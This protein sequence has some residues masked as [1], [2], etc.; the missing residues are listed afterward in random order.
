MDV[1]S[2]LLR[3]K[4]RTVPSSITCTCARSPSYFH[5]H[6]KVWPSK[7]VNTSPMP[8]L[9]LASRGVT[10]TPGTSWQAARAPATFVRSRCGTIAS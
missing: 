1:V 9:G 4:M 6:V 7:R 3:L 2:S 5:S 8:V 10:G